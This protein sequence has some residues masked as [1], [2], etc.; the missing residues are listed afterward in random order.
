[1]LLHAS[2][3]PV[4]FISFA[5]KWHDMSYTCMYTRAY[6]PQRSCGRDRGTGEEG[7]P[8]EMMRWKE[9]KGTR[10]GRNVA[11]GTIG[12]GGQSVS[13]G[14]VIQTPYTMGTADDK[15]RY[16]SNH[17]MEKISHRADA[18]RRTH[19][20]PADFCSSDPVFLRRRTRQRS[21]VCSHNDKKK[22]QISHLRETNTPQKN[23]KHRQHTTRL[24]RRVTRREIDN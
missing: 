19:K 11:A 3:A 24:L 5:C 7:S 13:G 14:P 15:S 10:R 16:N 8:T 9:G 22:V 18:T 1:M 6:T 2:S 4:C 20:Y 23:K 12:G 17:T 21:V